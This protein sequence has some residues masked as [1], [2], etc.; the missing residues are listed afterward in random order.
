MS[1]DTEHTTPVELPKPVVEHTLTIVLVDALDEITPYAGSAHPSRGGT[2]AIA[3]DGLAAGEQVQQA[4]IIAADD[5]PAFAS[6]GRVVRTSPPRPPPRRLPRGSGSA[7][8]V[9]RKR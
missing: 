6:G 4:V 7:P 2:P 1:A 8:P 9:P 5:G 3:P